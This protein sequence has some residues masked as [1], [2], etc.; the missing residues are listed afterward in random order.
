ML[1]SPAPANLHKV[2]L[3]SAGK[4]HKYK[5]SN[6]AT[7][8]THHTIYCGKTQGESN[9]IPK[10]PRQFRCRT[11]YRARREIACFRRPTTTQHLAERRQEEVQH[12]GKEGIRVPR[13]HSVIL[14]N[15]KMLTGYDTLRF[16]A[17]RWGSTVWLI[18]ANLRRR[19]KNKRERGRR[20]RKRRSV[21]RLPRP[22]PPS[23]RQPFSTAAVSGLMFAQI[24]RQTS[25]RAARRR[26]MMLR[27][28][29]SAHD[30]Q[31]PPPLIP[32]HRVLGE[33]ER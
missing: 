28:W 25:E 9:Q 4:V 14:W 15:P 12:K 8:F 3:F 2:I 22:R 21:G 19:D 13:I 10:C 33:I 27:G 16:V 18:N 23:D 32:I 6:T 31:R 5:T 7:P 29:V 26:S 30:Q 17:A 20:G 24:H 11:T 1:H